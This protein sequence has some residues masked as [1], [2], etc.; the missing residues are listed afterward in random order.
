MIELL[1]P[2]SRQMAEDLLSV[3]P[4][5]REH[6]SFISESGENRLKIQVP[7]PVG[8][9]G[10]SLEIYVLDDQD[11]MVCYASTH[12]H[13]FSVLGTED[14]PHGAIEFIREILDE[15]R[16]VVSYIWLGDA[17]TPNGFVASGSVPVGRIPSAN[18]EYYYTTLIRVRSWKGTYDAEFDAPY[19]KD[20]PQG[21]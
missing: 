10:D 1:E 19:I 3:F 4:N 11:V 15:R 18:H 9:N 20:K 16:A 8:S 6:I 14:D 17:A 21:D 13:F 12:G 2:F 7:P 5:W